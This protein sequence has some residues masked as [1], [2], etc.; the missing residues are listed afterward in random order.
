M[1]APN[2][3]GAYAHE[4][5]F[6]GWRSLISQRN[7]AVGP[8]LISKQTWANGRF[9]SFRHPL[10]AP[11]EVADLSFNGLSDTDFR[12]LLRIAVR[13]IRFEHS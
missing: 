5:R 6:V 3:F 9:S 13:A 1:C 11:Q 10:K 12:K 4:M 2:A 8:Q 7:R